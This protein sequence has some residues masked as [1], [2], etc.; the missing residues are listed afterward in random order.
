MLVDTFWASIGS[1]FMDLASYWWTGRVS[2]NIWSVRYG[3]LGL[4]DLALLP[5]GESARR[6]PYLR[7]FINLDIFK[8]QHAMPSLKASGPFH[9]GNVFGNNQRTSNEWQP[10]NQ[11]Y[12]FKRRFKRGMV[13]QRLNF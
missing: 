13:A 12:T 2:G 1:R 6:E 11:I 5:H 4:A 3:A 9:I 10:I 7:K 8:S